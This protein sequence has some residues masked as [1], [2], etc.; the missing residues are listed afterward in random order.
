MLEKRKIPAAESPNR[1]WKLSR[2]KEEVA[3]N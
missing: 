3:R 2:R 1:Y